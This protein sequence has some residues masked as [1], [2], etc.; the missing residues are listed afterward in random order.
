MSDEQVKALTPEQFTWADLTES[1]NLLW[2]AYAKEVTP[3]PSEAR[4]D[5]I[6]APEYQQQIK[7][8]F[9]WVDSMHEFV[10]RPQ[11][12]AWVEIE[13]MMAALTNFM[14]WVESDPP[15]DFYYRYRIDAPLDPNDS[16]VPDTVPKDWEE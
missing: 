9:D 12:M 14:R 2:S 3:A 10:R 8:L 4:P 1:Q 15:V 6:P 7:E 5:R 13:T 11:G 16:E